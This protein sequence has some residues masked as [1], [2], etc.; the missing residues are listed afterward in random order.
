MANEE[1]TTCWACGEKIA[2]SSKSC[3]E[4]GMPLE[5]A[6]IDTDDLD[7]FLDETA[8]TTKDD[9][10]P[11]LPEIDDDS[12]MPSMPDIS[13]D[14]DFPSMPEIGDDTSIIDEVSSME[15]SVVE[16]MEPDV[17]LSKVM[18]PPE[19]VLE[20]E[21]MPSMPDFDDVKFDEDEIE[22]EVVTHA[23]R[24]SLSSLSIKQISR[25]YLTQWTYWTMVFIVIAFASIEVLDPNFDPDAINSSQFDILPESF[26]MAWLSFLPMGWFFGYKLRQQNIIPKLLY[27]VYFII[28]QAIWL[29]VI[30]FLTQ[31]LFDPN[32]IMTTYLGITIYNFLI[33]FLTAG[34]LIYYAS[35]SLYWNKIFELTPIS[36]LNPSLMDT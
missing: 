24:V 4:C 22:E 21:D 13:G 3:P 2:A 20:D 1:L 33:G 26:L 27:S 25:L 17:E 30:V 5:E 8:D 18:E 15:S 6:S 11:S 16:T 36:D 12:D 35:Y 7:S 31:S 14:E 9:D 32:Y 28:G 29:L 10:F 23:E 34:F 19:K